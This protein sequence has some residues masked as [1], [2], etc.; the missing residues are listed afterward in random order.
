MCSLS[1]PSLVQT[2]T[3]QE[4]YKPPYALD[5]ANAP[6]ITSIANGLTTNTNPTVTVQANYGAKLTIK[7]AAKS[8]S[9]TNVPVTSVVLMAPSSA[10]HGFNNNQRLVYLPFSVVV[11]G[12]TSTLTA[13]LP[14]AP[15]AGSVITGPNVAPP[16]HYLLFLNNGKTNSRAWWVQL[17]TPR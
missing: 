8:G 11:T 3:R 10:T 16:Q 15:S 12:T 6:R 1:C 14:P 4:E 2:D 5:T 13:T 7:W 17:L 9:S